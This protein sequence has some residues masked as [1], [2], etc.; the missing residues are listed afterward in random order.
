[1]LIPDLVKYAMAQGGVLVSVSRVR[2]AS[3]N[4]SELD[5]GGK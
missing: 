5:K 4:K 3:E 1:M 2:V